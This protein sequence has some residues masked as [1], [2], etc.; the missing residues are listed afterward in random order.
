MTP[1]SQ[2]DSIRCLITF[3]PNISDLI[4]DAVCRFLYYQPIL[5]PL[6]GHYIFQ[7]NKF[8]RLIFRLLMRFIQSQKSWRGSAKKILTQ[9]SEY[10]THLL[11]DGRNLAN[12]L[13]NSAVCISSC[14]F[15]SSYTRCS[16]FLKLLSHSFILSVY[17]PIMIILNLLM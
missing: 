17:N 4:L 14:E 7:E 6:K 12:F 1:L 10:K 15:G 2:N 13:R 9:I 3:F 16:R 5:T 11:A 8:K